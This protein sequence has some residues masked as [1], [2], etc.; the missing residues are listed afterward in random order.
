M[1]SYTQS[2]VGA[3]WGPPAG[4]AGLIGQSRQP[5][6]QINGGAIAQAI[7][8]M[9][10]DGKVQKQLGK[11]AE[12]EF[13]AQMPEDPKALGQFEKV[14][15]TTDPTVFANLSAGEKA[16]R[17]LAS[18]TQQKLAQQQQE[19]DYRKYLMDAPQRDEAQ[20][21]VLLQALGGAQQRQVADS[22]GAGMNVNG[23]GLARMLGAA[24]GTAQGAGPVDAQGLLQ[25]LANSPNGR[26]VNPELLRALAVQQQK[27]NTALFTPSLGVAKAGGVQIPYMT[28]SRN[29]AQA[30]PEWAMDAQGN[31]SPRYQGRAL[32][33]GE[34]LRAYNDNQDRLSQ[35][36][37]TL[38][39]ARTPEGAKY[40]DP[41]ALTAEIAVLEQQQQELA[42]RAGLNNAQGKGAAQYQKGQRAQQNGKLYEFDGSE[43]KEVS[44]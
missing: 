8:G 18:Q 13:K 10:S 3:G 24:A 15:G 32:S 20:N 40:R 19:M 17:M 26:Q 1:P 28:T 14:W 22:A 31:I 35:L 27:E 34:A 43:W 6:N 29:S 30:F 11:N 39:I 9:I 2:P 37:Q 12:S 21:A 5:T 42:R 38:A 33:E 36:R 4:L 44:E 41:K 16:A 7:L 23:G 25:A